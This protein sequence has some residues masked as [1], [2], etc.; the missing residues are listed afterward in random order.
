M[1]SRLDVRRI[2]NP[3]G[4]PSISGNLVVPVPQTFVPTTTPFSVPAQGTIGGLDALDDR[5]FEAMIGRGP[6]GNDTLWTAHNLR[7]NALGQSNSSGD[8]VGA[9]W[10]QLGSLNTS[11]SLVQS[12]QLIDP[13]A[14]NPRQFWIPSI[15]MNG[16]GHASLNASTAGTGRFA[17]IALSGRLF[18]PPLN[19]TDTPEIPTLIPTGSYNLGS[20]MPRRWGDYSQ[21]M[22]DSS[23]NMSFWTFQEYASDQDEWGVRVIKLKPPPPA[24]PSTANPSTVPQG[25]CAVAVD[26]DGTSTDGSGFFDPGPDPGGPGYNSHITASASG[27][28]AVNDVIYTDPHM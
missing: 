25:H 9:R 14:S 28:V 19:T 5:L 27:G 24:M 16:Q 2:S 20:G 8:R 17:Q 3:G 12:G 21:T 7:M 6:D 10:Y 15:A 23:D 1:F 11:P 22:V 4:T 13:A 18:G 26:V